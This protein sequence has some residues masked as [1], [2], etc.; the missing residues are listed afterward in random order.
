MKLSEAL[1][2]RA[3]IQK[4]LQQVHQRLTL[5]VLVQEGEQPPENPEE[6]LAELDRLLNQ[7]R[8]LISRINRTNV[9]ATLPSGLSI[10][11]A[12]AQR[13]ALD[14]HY[15]M[16]QDVAKRASERTQR[17][18]RSEIRVV[19]TIEVAALRRQ[20]DGIAR[21]RRELDLAIQ[22]TNWTTELED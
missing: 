16:L 12:L 14:V 7:F 22:A 8:N 4:R 3:D 20:Q 17:F 10:T 19:P 21:E 18:T 2:L 1:V 5:S 6:L 9:R 13:D 15:R 11:E